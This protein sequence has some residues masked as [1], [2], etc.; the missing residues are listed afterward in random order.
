[1]TP[2]K[3]HLL[4]GPWLTIRGHSDFV[5]L[6]LSQ[7][8]L[9]LTLKIEDL[10]GFVGTLIGIFYFLSEFFFCL[11]FFRNMSVLRKILA[12]DAV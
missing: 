7:T 10:Q 12:E 5:K 9:P 2:K 3:W 8:G 4:Q 1:M 11:V 6:K